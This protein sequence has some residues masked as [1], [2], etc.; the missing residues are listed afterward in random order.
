VGSLE[1]PFIDRET[2]I[3]NKRA[4]GRLRDLADLERLEEDKE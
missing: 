1:V 2:L 3:R 4:T